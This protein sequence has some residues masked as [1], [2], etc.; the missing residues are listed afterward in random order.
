VVPKP[1]AVVLTSC[2]V[3]KLVPHA[4]RA[5]ATNVVGRSA[6]QDVPAGND[7]GGGQVTDA[8][9]VSCTVNGHCIV[10]SLFAI[11]TAIDLG[12]VPVVLLELVIFNVAIPQL[13]VAEGMNEAGMVAT[14]D[15]S[16]FILIGSGH[17]KVGPVVS[18]TSTDVAQLLVLPARSLTEK[19]TL[20]VPKPYA[21][22]F[23]SFTGPRSVPHAVRAVAT[24]V[25]GRSA[26][27]DLPAGSDRGGGQVIDAAE[28]SRT[29]KGQSMDVSFNAVST[30]MK[31]IEWRP[32]PVISG[33]L[34]IISA[35]I[36]QLSSATG[37]N[38]SGM[39][40]THAASV[41]SSI[42]SG[43]FKVGP[44]MS[45]TSTVVLYC[46]DSPGSIIERP[47]YYFQHYTWFF[48]KVLQFPILSHTCFEP[49]PQ[50]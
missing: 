13:S 31:W 7:I 44:A 27:H 46:I 6:T 10:I 8:A 36:P 38:D 12:P 22:V 19:G 50:M 49:L 14:H 28:V 39:V 4:V 9:E 17:V 3:L 42:G 33:A 23:D 35:S 29:V 47:L 34:V 40:A 45:T 41:V 26:T 1:Y 18:I 32:V 48:L 15:V 16:V 24:N 37:I 5:V 11:S 2:T 30:V 20:V 21:V 25:D 43:H